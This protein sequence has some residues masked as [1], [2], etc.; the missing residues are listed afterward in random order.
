[1]QALKQVARVRDLNNPEAVRG[2][3]S[4]SQWSNKTKV[5]FVDTYSTYLRFKGLK[6]NAPKYHVTTKFPF[7]P[8]E[9]ELDVLIAACGK[10]TSTVLQML[11]ET[12]MRIGELCIL[13]WMDI[14]G[15]RKTVST[16]PETGSNPRI[17]PIS[18]KLLGM[19]A[20][21][22]RNH[23]DNV[24][25]PQKRDLRAYYCTQRKAISE[26]LQNPRLLKVTFHTFRHWKGTVE[27]H[28]T[29]DIM[30]VKAVLGHKTITATLIYINL[31]ESMYVG[32]KDCFVC[33]VAHN[34][35][36][37]IALVEVGFEHVAD[38]GELHFYRK[39]K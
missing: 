30:H 27:Y 31:E 9:Q 15:E 17:L 13:K 3:L 10:T 2:W 32:E 36:E 12:G 23:G 22:A 18:D 16:T 8:T 28:I 34:E 7:I 11:K 33:K 14:N 5:K 39:R 19:L 37:E 21:L 24:F 1:M 35:A 25:Q 29:K 6:W 38:R 20:K 26:R 4:Q